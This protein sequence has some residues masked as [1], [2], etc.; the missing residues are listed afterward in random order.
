MADTI[1]CGCGCG[2]A[3]P[4]RDSRGRARSRASGHT[5]VRPL[6]DRFW[7]KVRKTD[8]CWYWTGASANGYGYIYDHGVR[9]ATHVAWELT[10]GP[11]PPDKFAL[12]HCDEPS[13]VRPDHLF[14]GT[15]A[16]N[17]ADRQAK[18]RTATGERAGARTKPHA[19]PRG[20]QRADAKLSAQAISEARLRHAGG[21][22]YAELAREIGVDVQTIRRAIRGETWRHL[23]T[24]NTAGR[25]GST[26]R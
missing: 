26:S 16:D 14:V 19:F 11:F 9:R 23:S 21:A 1:L 20:E 18:R 10:Y 24:S 8:G 3:I 13:C 15:H 22:S 12:R 6:A 17:M 2:T 7:E 4:A 5:N 25:Q